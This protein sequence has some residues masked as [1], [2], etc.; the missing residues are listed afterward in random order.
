MQTAVSSPSVILLNDP[1]RWLRK[2]AYGSPRRCGYPETDT[3]ATT[4]SIRAADGRH[5]AQRSI[6]V[7]PDRLAF[8]AR[9]VG[10]LEDTLGG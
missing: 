5:V 8:A 10:S 9:S 3:L 1:R 7:Q 6:V 4:S 2:L